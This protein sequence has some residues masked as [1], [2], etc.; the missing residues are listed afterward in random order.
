MKRIKNT[1][2]LMVESLEDRS[3]PSSNTISLT[4]VGADVGEDP[5]VAAFNSDGIAR[6]QSRP[7]GSDFRG[8]VRVAVGNLTGDSVPNVIAVPGPGHA[9]IV[10]ILDGTTGQVVS[11]VNAFETTFQGGL[12]VA[13]ADFDNDGTADIVVSPDR[14][15]GPRI[16]V[17]SGK[18]NSTLADFYGIDDV[19]FRGGARV[20]VGDVNADGRPDLIVS[21]GFGGGPRIAVFDGRTL[22][23]NANPRRL[24]PDFYA[25][26]PSLR[27][28]AFVAA[29]DLQT[30]GFADLIFG[31][32]PGGG[33]RVLAVSA[34][35][36]LSR[37]SDAALRNPLGNFFA[38]DQNDRG[39]VRVSVGSSM[40]NQPIVLTSSGSGAS[41]VAAF[42]LDGSTAEAG[43]VGVS[44][45]FVAGNLG[46]GQPDGS[47][48][49]EARTNSNQA[50]TSSPVNSANSAILQIP[51]QA[52]YDIVMSG[53]TYYGD[54]NF[55]SSSTHFTPFQEFNLAG[56]L[57]VT[58][59]QD[60]NNASRN[61]VNLRDVIINTGN[62][63][64]GGAGVLQYA[65]NTRLH[66]I[67]QGNASQGATVDVAIVSTD[68]AAGT[69][70]IRP[71]PNIARTS[72]LNTMFRSGGLTANPYNILDGLL[73]IQF[74]NNG[75]R[76]DGTL[77]L[78]G[79]GYI[80]PGTTAISARFSG[81]VR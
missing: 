15:G 11:K 61:G 52:G 4:T 66:Q 1:R 28:G 19:N 70:Q 42:H 54:T 25:F 64:I 13:C 10:A 29:G 68:L 8:G 72:Q 43:G 37:G 3:L 33:P 56:L 41:Q 62:I 47:V 12:F 36:L 57:F 58:P 53:T 20:A 30:T 21:A 9:P 38:G 75:T 44:G 51:I 2:A 77:E 59:T 16:R 32:G 81:T 50:N 49:V 78:Y 55:L 22:S 69:I 48:G 76:I 46:A 73:S 7:F 60:P 39:G 18:D 5:T 23:G 35:T 65:T 24:M 14:N 40:D 67:F 80:Y 26:E 71:D 27:N 34:Q 31:G 74:S 6:F 17:L 79:T 63:G 45:G